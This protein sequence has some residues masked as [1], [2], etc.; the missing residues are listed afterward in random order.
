MVQNTKSQKDQCFRIVEGIHHL[1]CVLMDL[2]MNSKDLQSPMMLDYIA[3]FALTLQKIDSC[4]RAQQQ[5]G[6]IKRLFKQSELITQLDSCEIELKAAL[7]NFTMKHGIT[8]ASALLE[9][10]TDAEMQHQELLELL[11][12]QIG[13]FDNVSSLWLTN[14]PVA[15][16]FPTTLLTQMS[17]W[18]QQLVQALAWRPHV[19]QQNT[20][21]TI[22]KF[23]CWTTLPGDF[24]Q[25]S[26]HG[27]QWT[28]TMRG[29]ERPGKV[30]WTHPFLHP[31]VP[32]TQVAAHQTFI[33]IADG[34]HNKSE[35]DRLL[36]ITDNIPLAVQL[37][38]TIAGSEG[39]ELTLE[40]WNVERTSMLS[41]GTSKY[42]N[43]KISIQL[44]LSSPRMLSSPDALQL[45]SLMSLLS[46]G[47]SDHDLVQ[48]RLPI[49]RILNCKATL[50]CTSLAYVLGDFKY[51]LELVNEG[52]ELVARDGMR[53]AQLENMLMS[54]E[55]EVYMCKGDYAKAQQV[56]EVLLDQT[57]AVLASIQHGFFLINFA[58][59]DIVTG[60]SAEIVSQ[61]LDTATSIFRKA[62]DLPGLSACEVSRAD[63]Q[64]RE[65]NIVGAR[66]EY[67][68]LFSALQRSDSELSCL[69]LAKLANPIYPVHADTEVAKWAIV[70]FAFTMRPSVR[71]IPAIHHAL[72]C[73]GDVFVQQG[74]TDEALSILAVALDGFTRLDIHRGRASGRAHRSS[75]ESNLTLKRRKNMVN[76][77][78]NREY[79]SLV[80]SL[81][82]RPPNASQSQQAHRRSE[83]AELLAKD[84]GKYLVR[85]ET[86]LV[87]REERTEM[88]GALRASLEVDLSRLKSF[89]SKGIFG[90]YANTSKMALR[91]L[92]TISAPKLA[93]NDEVVVG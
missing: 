75:R 40:R 67:I 37:I 87:V 12:S 25:S 58:I 81:A 77:A 65:G 53:G 74:M 20:L 82:C 59:L 68:Q 49:P 93:T 10:S 30:R 63:L 66:K 27:N 32:L 21:S 61:K 29:A 79:Y 70:F 35:V 5:L 23:G 16:S 22:S 84:R 17:L 80:L 6:T 47:I 86:R 56:H 88:W 83:G 18:L 89:K 55:A 72:R 60:V 69:C 28:I 7:S 4:L 24:G 19:P 15:T 13:S 36:G 14:I 9:F 57:S 78:A 41:D 8:L 11:S 3:Q 71:N 54:T 76:D 51:S 42:S 31:L 44:S 26:L 46:D 34:I 90:K 48:R 62:Q 64:L 2:S 92:K 1:L 33:E 38:A 45:F 39:C 43:L 52:K 73:L 91:Y 85:R 50:L